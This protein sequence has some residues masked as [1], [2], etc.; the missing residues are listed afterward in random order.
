M[1][2]A[3]LF[4]EISHKGSAELFSFADDPILSDVFSADSRSEKMETTLN[5]EDTLIDVKG[6]M[7]LVKLKMNTEKTEFIIFGHSKQLEKCVTQ[8]S[9]VVGDMIDRSSCICYLGAFLDEN[10][11]L[12]EHVKRISAASIRHFYKIKKIRKFLTAQATEHLSLV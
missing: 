4:T 8:H 12:K 1:Y 2:T 7:N 5:L 11:T 10:L 6:W 3:T 9:N